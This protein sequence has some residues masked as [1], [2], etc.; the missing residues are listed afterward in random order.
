MSLISNDGDSHLCPFVLSSKSSRSAGSNRVSAQLE[1]RRSSPFRTVNL[2]FILLTTSALVASVGLDANAAREVRFKDYPIE[3]GKFA[4]VAPSSGALSSGATNQATDANRNDSGKADRLIVFAARGS[5]KLIPIPAG[6]APLV[7]A[8]K[9]LPDGS[10]SDRMDSTSYSVRRDGS[11][12]ILELK[13]PQSRADW[14]HLNL[15]NQ[16]ELHFE[17]EA[18][19]VPVEIHLTAGTVQASGW[20]DSLAITLQDGSVKLADGEGA[21]HVSIGRGE[22]KLEKWKGLATIESHTAKVQIQSNDGEVKVFNFSGETLLTGVKGRARV[23]AK[24]GSTTASKIDGGFEFLNGRGTLSLSQVAG[25]VR[26]ENDEG[27]VTLSLGGDKAKE[28]SIESD[29]I[30]E[31]NDGT[32]S[33]KPPTNSGA[34]LKLTSEEGAIQVPDSVAVPKAAGPKSVTARL[35]GT[36]RG[37]ILVRAKRGTIRIR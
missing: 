34:L 12:L 1:I 28:D 14:I 32:V 23:E 3:I 37:T 20:K 18:P 13:G 24:T 26:G 10:K 4:S 15:A 2:V 31:S 22:V 16:P 8:R 7:R 36:T 25:A 6:R 17:V 19:S 21:V 29:V 35:P 27:V 9:V 33:I 11:V 5:V 30:V